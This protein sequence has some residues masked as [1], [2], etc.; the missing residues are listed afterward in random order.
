MD[1]N[2]LRCYIKVCSINNVGPSWVGLNK[3]KQSFIENSL[4]IKLQK[5]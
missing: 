3:F 1:F 2:I 5:R 4:E